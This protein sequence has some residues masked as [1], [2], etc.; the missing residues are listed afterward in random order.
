MF[1]ISIVLNYNALIP[2]DLSQ[3]ESDKEV[4]VERDPLANLS[5]CEPECLTANL[6]QHSNYSHQ[7]KCPHTH[8]Y[9]LIRLLI[10]L[11]AVLAHSIYN[12]YYVDDFSNSEEL[13]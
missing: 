7:P 5:D 12:T 8:V 2:Q 10:E 11:T 9:R 6:H 1:L 3:I 4:T 13:G